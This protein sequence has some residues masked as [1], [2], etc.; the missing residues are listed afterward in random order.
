MNMVETKKGGILG[1][2]ILGRDRPE[3]LE[4]THSK[5]APPDD[6]ERARKREFC[7]QLDAS[8]LDEEN[9]QRD[10]ATLA[11]ELYK[12][13]AHSY[14]VGR[15]EALSAS[16]IFHEHIVGIRQQ[17]INHKKILEDIKRRYC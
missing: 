8:I 16:L 17:E 5:P 2:G 9:A 6:A 13:E 12:A 15:R 7:R 10:Y 14:D 1:F 3:I 11:D 4:K